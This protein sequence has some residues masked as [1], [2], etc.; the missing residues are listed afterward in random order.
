MFSKLLE[1]IVNRTGGDTFYYSSK[2][3]VFL[4]DLGIGLAIFYLIHL[5]RSSLLWAKLSYLLVLLIGVVNMAIVNQQKAALPSW[6]GLLIDH[7]VVLISAALAAF[8]ST[9]SRRIIGNL[10]FLGLLIPLTLYLLFWHGILINGLPVVIGI[11]LI[12]SFDYYTRRSRQ[13]LQAQIVTEKQDSEFR[14]VSHIAHGVK[15]QL[16]IARTPLET[17]IRHLEQQGTLQQELPGRLL[18]GSRE[19]IGDA[20][21]KTLQSLGQ[22]GDV[23]ANARQLVGREISPEDFEEVDLGELFFKEIVPPY[24]TKEYRIE[25][26][27]QLRRPVRLHRASFVEAI[28]NLIRNAEVHGFSENCTKRNKVI[29]FRLKENIKAV[30][31]DYTNN[32]LPFPANLTERDFLT[33]GTKSSA[34]P[35]EGLGGAW[36]GKVIEAHQG[37]FQIIRDKQP[38]HFRIILP[39][40]I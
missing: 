11:I 34:S 29:T 6:P 5:I 25:V 19:T 18:D 24:H 33:F 30:T 14:I 3:A 22:I 32:G 37:S 31:L 28:N 20:L 36:V 23:V 39:K 2:T 27:C 1:K 17:V 40:R 12:T 8:P 10:V 16:L 15:P 4:V 21:Q 26:H 9:L 7:G 38:L 13:E 35:G